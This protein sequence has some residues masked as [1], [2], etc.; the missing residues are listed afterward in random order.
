MHKIAEERISITI[1]LQSV[2]LGRRENGGVVKTTWL[3]AN[4]CQITHTYQPPIA[5]HK[6]RSRLIDRERAFTCGEQTQC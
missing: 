1:E 6:S 5:H 4:D 3:L 2:S